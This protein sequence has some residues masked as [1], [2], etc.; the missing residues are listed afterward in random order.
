MQASVTLS[1]RKMAV[2]K[3]IPAGAEKFHLLDR[4]PAFR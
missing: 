4:V 3:Y 2:N 1:N